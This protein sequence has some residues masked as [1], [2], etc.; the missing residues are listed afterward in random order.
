MDGSVDRL[1]YKW[2]CSWM[3][4]YMAISVDLQTDGSVDWQM[5][6]SVNL[7]IGRSMYR[8]ITRTVDLKMDRWMDRQIG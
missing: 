2:I 5:G 8:N 3:G 6:G 7:W 4:Q 1:S